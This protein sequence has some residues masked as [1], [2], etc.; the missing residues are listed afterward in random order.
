MEHS[1]Q[2]YAA[3]LVGKTITQWDDLSNKTRSVVAKRVALDIS[4]VV[5]VYGDNTTVIR[6]SPERIDQLI[7][8]GQAMV[9]GQ[10]E[11]QIYI[12]RWWIK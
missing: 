1:I 4:G 12:I 7:E 6:V 8:T 9:R 10:I 5:N 11:G 2:Y 3:H